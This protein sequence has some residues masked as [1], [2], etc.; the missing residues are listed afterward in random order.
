M[1]WQE[2]G[3]A[4]T[5]HVRF[6]ALQ[7]GE[8]TSSRTVVSS[9]ALFVN[10]ADYPSVVALGGDTLVAH[11]LQY[12]GPGT[13]AYQVRL[14]VSPDAGTTWSSPVIPQE[15][16]TQTEHGF[17]TLLPR[18]AGVEVF[19][20]DGRAYADG[21]QQMSLRNVWIGADGIPGRESLLDSRT[22]D[23]CQ[24]AVAALG[25]TLIVVYRGRSEEE[26]R[27]IELVRRIDGQW[28]KP[29]SVYADGWRIDACPVNG[30]AIAA[31]GDRLLVTWFT[32]AGGDARVRGALSTDGGAS[33][34]PAFVVDDGR[35]IGRVSAIP[36]DARRAAVAWVEA[37][38]AVEGGAEVRVR[39]IDRDGG[40][41]PSERVVR[42]A[43]ARASGFPS[44]A[45]LDGDLLVAW[46]DP[47]AGVVRLSRGGIPRAADR[48]D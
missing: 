36:L 24:T 10:W 35:P 46:T 23:C 28:T 42:G 44:L 17:V 12:N 26:V 5:T 45:E 48:V 20:L 29:T 33:F 18:A 40:M 14:A 22:C 30:P 19:W 32:A 39:L 8:W 3:T 41:S 43:S 47:D 4:D 15:T 37:L 1:S 13:Y 9:P 2:A 7:G 34:G 25:D 21:P 27:D 11:W 16:R 31:I 6:A 38:D